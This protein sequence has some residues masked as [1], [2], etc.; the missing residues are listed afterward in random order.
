MALPARHL[1]FRRTGSPSLA[2]PPQLAVPAA[3]RSRA[4]S[5][6][7]GDRRRARF[8]DRRGRHEQLRWLITLLRVPRDD[9][10][11]RLAARFREASELAGLVAVPDRD[12][13]RVRLRRPRGRPTP[14]RAADRV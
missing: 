2:A 3:L 7:P 10:P 1:P 6:C 4:G 12:R 13:P 9:G 5:P 11:P 14:P 8:P